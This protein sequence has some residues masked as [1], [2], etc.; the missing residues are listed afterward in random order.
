M[1]VLELQCIIDKKKFQLYIFLAKAKLS[2][3]IQNQRVQS[4]WYNIKTIW[5]LDLDKETPKIL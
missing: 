2:H 3:F 5:G 1:D 4:N